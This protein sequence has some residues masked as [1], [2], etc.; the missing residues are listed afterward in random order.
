MFLS[1]KFLANLEV[2]FSKNGPF[3][4]S[5]LKESQN[6]PEV[7]SKLDRIDDG[8]FSVCECA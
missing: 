2:T 7:N 3:I 8:K 6:R 1:S 5:E 4:F